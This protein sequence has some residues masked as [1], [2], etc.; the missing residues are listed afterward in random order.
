MGAMHQQQRDIDKPIIKD[1]RNQTAECVATAF[2]SNGYSPDIA[3]AEREIRRQETATEYADFV[4][5]QKW[6]PYQVI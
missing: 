6:H 4:D 5:S 1:Q 2:S 3:T